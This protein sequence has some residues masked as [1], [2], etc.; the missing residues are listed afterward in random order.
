MNQYKKLISYIYSLTNISKLKMEL[1][2]GSNHKTTE[3]VKFTK[4]T[5]PI[6]AISRI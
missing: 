3:S 4:F 5:E 2:Y 6:N 1:N